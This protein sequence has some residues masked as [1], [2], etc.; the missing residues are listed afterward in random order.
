MCIRGGAGVK[1][2]HGS[3]KP[4]LLRTP[5]ILLASLTTFSGPQVS[6]MAPKWHKIAELL[7]LRPASFRSAAGVARCDA[8]ASHCL[9]FFWENPWAKGVPTFQIPLRGAQKFIGAPPTKILGTPLDV[10][11]EIAICINS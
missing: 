2:S 9:Q 5:L 11:I 6:P 1:N 3:L 10:N 4:T 8:T 7:G